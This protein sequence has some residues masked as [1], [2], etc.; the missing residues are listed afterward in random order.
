MDQMGFNVL[1]IAF[2]EINNFNL[3]IYYISDLNQ[4][5]AITRDRSRELTKRLTS[6]IIDEPSKVISITRKT[7]RQI[8]SFQHFI[9]IHFID[10]I[11]KERTLLEI[12][13]IDRPGLLHAIVNTFED[14][15]IIMIDAKI[16]TLGERV[17]DIFFIQNTSKL[18][19]NELQKKALQSALNDNI[20]TL[21]NG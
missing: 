15:N 11:E 10:E 12:S 20:N 4:S 21:T 8:N 6:Y 1:D 9:T 19:L 5:Q 13:T 18:P 14:L 16:S 2:N 7:S 17:D 3:E